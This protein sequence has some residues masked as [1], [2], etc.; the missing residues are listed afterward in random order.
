MKTNEAG[1]L[2]LLYE[3][4]EELEKALILVR[5]EIRELVNY[6]DKN[7][8]SQNGRETKGAKSV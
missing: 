2:E 6:L 1:A 7:K 3:K 4:E 5:E 8:E